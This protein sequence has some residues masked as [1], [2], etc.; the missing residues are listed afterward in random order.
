[1]K[2]LLPIVLLLVFS[3]TACDIFDKEERRVTDDAFIMMEDIVSPD[4]QHRILVYQYDTGAF[5]YSR[6][7][8]TVTPNEYRDLNLADYE[9][10]DGYKAV[11]WSNE[12][13]LL[14]SK[15]EPYYY[16]QK[17]GELNTGDVFMDVK[18]RLVQKSEVEQNQQ[19]NSQP[20]KSNAN[21]KQ[22]KNKN[23]R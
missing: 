10:P 12:G 17:L 8:W 6:V 4:G 15:W 7:W 14:V 9:I 19:E 20:E 13:E 21:S 22:E 16:R 11:G 23:A 18:V 2:R 1:M 5:G 3:I